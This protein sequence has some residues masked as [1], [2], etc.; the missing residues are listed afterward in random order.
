MAEFVNPYIAGAP[1]AEAKMFFGRE[2][3]FA[4]IE[5]SLT[6]QYVDNILVIHGQRRVGKTSILKQLP[7]RLSERYIPIFL[8]L[9]GRT[10]TSLDRFL[11]WMGREIGR[12]LKKDHGIEIAIPEREAFADDPEKFESQFLP[13]LRSAIEP[14]VVLLTFDE[15][16]MLEQAEVKAGLARPLVATLR[17]MMGSEGLCFIYSIGSSGRKLENMQAAYTDFFKAALYKKVSFLGREETYHLVAEPVAGLLEYHPQAAQRIY[18]LTF[19]HPYFTQLVCHELFSRC[20][21]SGARRIDPGDVDAVLDDVIERGTVNLKFVWDEAD[22]LQKWTLAALAQLEGK[23]EARRLGDF[24]RRQGVRFAEAELNTALLHLQ[25][26]DVLDASYAFVVHLMRIWLQKNRPLERVREELV[27]VNPI[28]SRYLEIGQEHRELGQVEQAIES[29]R[30]AL[31]F[32]ASNR[33]ARLGI[34]EIYLEQGDCLQACTEFEQVVALDESDVAALTGLC[35]AYMRLGEQALAD[36]QPEAAMP[37][38]EK[39]LA[40]NPEHEEGRRSMAAIY[41]ERAEQALAQQRDEPALEAYRQALGYTPEDAALEARYRQAQE[42][43]LQRTLERLLEQAEQK[44][45][46]QDWEGA[47]AKL[48]E[49]LEL[50]TDQAVLQA[51]IQAAQ[52]EQRQ[53]QLNAIYEQAHTH[54]KAERWEK[55]AAAWQQA[56]AFEPGDAQAAQGLQQAQRLARLS[57]DYRAARQALR[58]RQHDEAIRL[59]K[60]IIA[61]DETYK[62]ASQLLAKAV[63]AAHRERPRLPVRQILW[64]AGALLAVALVILAAVY[65]P[66]WLNQTAA[67]TPATATV[68]LAQAS[69]T[70]PP[71]LSMTAPPQATQTSAPTPAATAASLAAT[72]TAS[73]SITPTITESSPTATAS[74]T[75]DPRIQVAAWGAPLSLPETAGEITS[76][77]AALLS[78]L[79]RWEA[80]AALTG[81]AWSAAAQGESRLAA[82][83][84]DQTIIYYSN[85]Q[86][87]LPIE[88]G[89]SMDALVFSP[90][91]QTLPCP[92]GAAFD[93]YSTQK[94]SF[95]TLPEMRNDA[96]KSPSGWAFMPSNYLVAVINKGLRQWRLS[97][98]A[99]SG[100]QRDWSINPSAASLALSPDGRYLATGE[101]ESGEV[102]LWQL[103]TQN[104]LPFAARSAILTG[105]VGQ[106]NRLCFSP[107]AAWLASGGGGR[108]IVRQM[109]QGEV[110]FQSED[111]PGSLSSLE[112]SPSGTILAAAGDVIMLWNVADGQVL[113]TLDSHSSKVTGLAWSPDGKYLASTSADGTLRLWGI[114][115]TASATPQPQVSPTSGN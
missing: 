60:G 27:E 25:E 81:V 64:G 34:A 12:V 58:Q 100:I 91:G 83:A 17:R 13:E 80:P 114:G 93:L 62:D 52:A 55:A 99:I 94:G 71:T 112:F 32:E 49:A 56:L 68:A 6:G 82:A 86:S 46:V 75:S 95:F 31:K 87:P 14:R 33:L 96:G 109:P 97:D 3:I 28:A 42:L 26:K 5:R 65:L 105:H 57:A 89:F 35:Q 74:P 36:D 101:T 22:D 2:D 66:S 16:D 18:E 73:P 70:L 4:W 63:D 106:V 113:A 51:R 37:W 90:D 10:H 103:S 24:L 54:T 76:S 69:Q 19:G 29:F 88:C 72:E 67:P 110:V 47:L 39:V 98:S 79:A 61:E 44:R 43:R 9:Q 40:I 85:G 108:I 20:Q 102:W 41:R 115:E 111:L 7:N 45:L 8:D 21:K 53:A 1:V 48:E 30:Q 11:W 38:F 23:L 50:G 78:E 15:F 59:L 77:N 92:N 107:D 84:A 104:Q